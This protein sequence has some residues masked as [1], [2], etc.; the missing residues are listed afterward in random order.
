MEHIAMKFCHE[1]Q[2]LP[3]IYFVI[4]RGIRGKTFIQT[5]FLLVS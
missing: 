1:F 5:I 4:I 2:E 3:R